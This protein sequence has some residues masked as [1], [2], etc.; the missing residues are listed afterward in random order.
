M[1]NR[2]DSPCW[3]FRKLVPNQ[4]DRRIGAAGFFNTGTNLLVDLLKDNCKGDIGILWQVPWGKHSFATNSRKR[5]AP[6]YE[7]YNKDAVLTVVTTRHPYSWS[8][9]MCTNPYIVEWNHTSQNCPNLQSTVETWGGHRNLMEFWNAWYSKY[10]DQV[11]YPKLIVRMED[12]TLHPHHTIETICECAGG[13]C[14]G[15]GDF[16][17]PFKSVK[18][19]RSG[20]TSQ[21]GLMKAW[22]QHNQMLKQGF[23]PRSGD[24]EIAKESLNDNL[25]NR[26]GY[27]QPP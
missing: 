23:F 20:H 18:D 2:S 21:T 7:S 14:V 17:F 13:T 10:I 6:G 15:S 27:K 16:T 3:R 11:S 1:I 9:S 19:G 26:F 12:L 25:M 8:K 5:T 22:K 24:Y 4:K